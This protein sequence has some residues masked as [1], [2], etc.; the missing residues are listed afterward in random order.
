MSEKCECVCVLAY[1]EKRFSLIIASLTLIWSSISSIIYRR[2]ACQFNEFICKQSIK[3]NCLLF[4]HFFFA[5]LQF[6]FICDFFAVF[7]ISFS[8]A[9]WV[10]FIFFHLDYSANSISNYHDK[11]INYILTLIAL[12]QNVIHFAIVSRVYVSLLCMNTFYS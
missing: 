9:I 4:F 11:K 2:L 12:H 7:F 1:D 10:L 5:F 3:S 8:T 6:Y